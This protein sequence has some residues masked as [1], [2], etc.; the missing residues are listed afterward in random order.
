M[1]RLGS[2]STSRLRDA[3]RSYS[4]AG[5]RRPERTIFPFASSDPT[6]GLPS[7]SHASA[8]GWVSSWA[9]LGRWVGAGC[10]VG[11]GYAPTGYARE[12]GTW[13]A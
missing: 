11:T 4:G 6:C 5:D 1:T 2:A 10:W 13:H 7:R 8:S 3:S 12:G 9:H